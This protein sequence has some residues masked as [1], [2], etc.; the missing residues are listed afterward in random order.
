MHAVHYEEPMFEQEEGKA[1][2]EGKGRADEKGGG[3][4][5]RK[6]KHCLLSRRSFFKTWERLLM[7]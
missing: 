7:V 4:K 2:G 3:A 1:E 5:E 6:C